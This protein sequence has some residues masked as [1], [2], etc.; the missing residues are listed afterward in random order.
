[1][2]LAASTLKRVK[3]T[4]GALWTNV[5][6]CRIQVLNRRIEEY[7][8]QPGATILLPRNEYFDDRCLGDT[9]SSLGPT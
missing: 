1:M 3:E 9:K 7:Q 6:G 5:S 4:N 8:H 2:N